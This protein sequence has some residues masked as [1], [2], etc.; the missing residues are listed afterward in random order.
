ML[1][2]MHSEKKLRWSILSSIALIALSTS[3]GFVPPFAAGA[4][5]PKLPTMT[6]VAAV[7]SVPVGEGTDFTVYVQVPN[8]PPDLAGGLRDLL[9]S[10]IVQSIAQ[11]ATEPNGTVQAPTTLVTCTTAA[12]NKFPGYPSRQAETAC[13][14][15][16]VQRVD[17]RAYSASNTA[18][19]F[20]G[21]VGFSP[22]G[23]WSINFVVTG[24]YFGNT[25]TLTASAKLQVGASTA[26]TSTKS[27][28]L[29]TLS[30]IPGLSS[31]SSTQADDFYLYVQ[32]PNNSPVNGAFYDL[33]PAFVVQSITESDTFNGTSSGPTTFITCSTNK[34]GQNPGYPSRN[35]ETTCTGI[36][37]YQRVIPR[38]YWGSNTG[39]WFLGF[40]FGGSRGT[41]TATFTVVGLFFGSSITLTASATV[42]IT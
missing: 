23:T 4:P 12:T 24:L 5:T 37:Y 10:F 21:L 8:N 41:F 11:G 9:P 22:G 35:A 26:T 32:V 40:E 16:Y 27:S 39:I 13:S 2:Y 38:A 31:L 18:I 6:V 25:I 15:I 42:T 14:G 17:A 36:I 34:T 1:F 19:Y 7:P 33:Q 28:A 30:V 3:L 29:P 20:L